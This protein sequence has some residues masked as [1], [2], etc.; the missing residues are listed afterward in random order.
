[1]NIN[2]EPGYMLLTIGAYLLVGTA[3]AFCLDIVLLIRGAGSALDLQAQLMAIQGDRQLLKDND[4]YA[5][6]Y[7][8]SVFLLGAHILRSWV[9]DGQSFLYGLCV[10]INRDAEAIR[11]GR[12]L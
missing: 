12:K 3:V 2:L 9:V 7:E 10:G 1:M 11:E 5:E 4:A 6:K 8:F